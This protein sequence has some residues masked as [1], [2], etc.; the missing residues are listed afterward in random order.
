[1]YPELS[2]IQIEEI[3]VALNAIMNEI[4]PS[5]PASQSIVQ[6]VA[7]PSSLTTSG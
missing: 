5:V 3:G 7:A 4:L 1:M 6:A 2:E